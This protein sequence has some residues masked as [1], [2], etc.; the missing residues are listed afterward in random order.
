[1]QSTNVTL[2]ARLPTNMFTHKHPYVWS[3]VRLS[4]LIRGAAA[5]TNANV[6]IGRMHLCESTFI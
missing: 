3:Q 4:G 1:M 6:G 5:T 2:A